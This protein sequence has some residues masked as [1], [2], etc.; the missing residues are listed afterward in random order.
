[1]LEHTASVGQRKLMVAGSQTSN[2][3]PELPVLSHNTHTHTHTHTHIHIL[4]GKGRGMKVS[5]NLPNKAHHEIIV[6][7]GQASKVGCY[8]AHLGEAFLT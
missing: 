3:W 4:M 7:T 8:L 6:V 1:M 2:L 5:Q